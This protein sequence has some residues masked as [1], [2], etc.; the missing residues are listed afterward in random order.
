LFALSAV[1][2]HAGTN[3][4]NDYYDFVHGVDPEDDPDPAHVIPRGIVSPTFMRRSGHVY[5]LLG[6][7]VGLPIGLIR[8]VTFVLAGLA[9]A[10]G[11][12][13][14]TNARFSLKYRGLGDLLVF[15]LMGPALVAMGEWALVGRVSAAS[16]LVSLP[17]AFLVASILHGNNFRNM[18]SDARAGVT[19]LAGLLGIEAS[20]TMFAALVLAP[21]IAVVGFAAAGNL[22]WLSLLALLT[23]PMA[24]ALARRVARASD[25]ARLVTLPMA[26]ARLHMLFGALYVAGILAAEVWPA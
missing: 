15:F 14:Y 3:V 26:C 17:I 19:T 9:G 5:F 10:L 4:L 2:F 21:F 16:V 13:A 6:I 18:E 12:Y 1:L 11:A 24:I 7:A 8:G 22:G 20:K 25:P 23:L